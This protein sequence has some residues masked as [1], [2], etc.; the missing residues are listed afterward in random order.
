MSKKNGSTA[1]TVLVIEDSATQALHLRMILEEEG[2]RVL[3]APNGRKG[4]EAAQRTNPDLIV[5]DVLMPGMDG[6]QVCRRLKGTPGLAEIPV[7]FFTSS[8][9]VESVILGLQEGALDYIPK[10]A[11]ADAVLLE[12]LRHLGFVPERRIYAHQ[13]SSSASS[14]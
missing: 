3:L 12:T 14:Q 10:D 7:I 2:L 6:F 1:K 11:F 13:F 5:L 4:L 8:D 9:D